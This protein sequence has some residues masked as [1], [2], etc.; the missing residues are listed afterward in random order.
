M[1]AAIRVIPKTVLLLNMMFLF[2]GL[3][4][5]Q[6]DD[7][8]MTVA[9]S[10]Y[11][12]GDYEGAV[13]MLREV[14]A[15]EQDNGLAQRYLGYALQGLG[16]HAE[17]VP[18]LLGAIEADSGD[19][20]LFAA[21]GRSYEAM[22]LPEKAE[23]VYHECLRMDSRNRTVLQRILQLCFDKKDWNSAVYYASR[24]VRL[25]PEN[26]VD[27]LHLGLAEMNRGNLEAAASA[28]Q[29]GQRVSPDNLDITLTLSSVYLQMDLLESALRI[30]TTGVR[31]HPTQHRLFRRIGEIFFKQHTF[32]KADSCFF[33]A[34]ALGDSSAATLRLLGAS[35]ILQ[36]KV[37]EAHE[38]LGL[39]FEKDSTD[40]LTAYYLALTMEK[41]DSLAAAVRW[42]GKSIELSDA[43]FI[44]QVLSQMSTVHEQSGNLT[45]AVQDLKKA[46][47]ISTNKSRLYFQLASL[48]DRHYAD[49]SAAATYYEKYVQQAAE[50]DSLMVGHAVRRLRILKEREHFF[51]K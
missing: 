13:T 27:L 24:L 39:S 4:R 48:Y 33:Q 3:C 21:L 29:H 44:G 9:K 37:P 32:N 2:G 10:L 34:V 31:H 41:E 8:L 28:L 45:A 22:G 6:T 26:A 42:L 51:R 36:D 18:H 16:K 46:I 5:A 23:D 25:D 15:S 20:R 49:P 38:H 12:D 50:S 30:L 35:E 14:V 47:S 7:S 19:V 43:V 17:A 11:G 1:N 40:P